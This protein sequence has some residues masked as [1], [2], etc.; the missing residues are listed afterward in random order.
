VVLEAEGGLL[1]PRFYVES[2][3]L[4][5]L[6]RRRRYRWSVGAWFDRKAGWSRTWEA[7]KVAGGAPQGLTLLEAAAA[8][9]PGEAPIARHSAPAP[10]VAAADASAPAQPAPAAQPAPIATQPAPAAAQPAPAALQP[11]PTAVQPAPAAAQPAPAAAQ[12]APTAAQPAPQPAPAAPPPVPE[13]SEHFTDAHGG[14]FYYY[15]R[16]TQETLW[17]APKA[18]FTPYQRA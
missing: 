18:P 8:P 15:N 10:A 14:R 2:V 3:S 1:A 4:E 17:E 5:D 9:P 12:P 11:A 7:D 6:Q 16:L 13:W